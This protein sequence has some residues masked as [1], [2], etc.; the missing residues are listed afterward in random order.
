MTTPTTG[1]QPD[2]FESNRPF[3]SSQIQNIFQ[4]PIAEQQGVRYSYFRT[5]Q[6]IQ[7]FDISNRPQRFY[8]FAIKCATG[9]F[10]CNSE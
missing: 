3:V 1:Q 2:A 9:Y 10:V 6:P 4:S 5:F 8:E 7:P